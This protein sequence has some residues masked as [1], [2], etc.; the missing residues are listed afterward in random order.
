MLERHHLQIIKE[1]QRLGSVT[2]AASSLHLSQS[3][4]SHAIAKLEQR[5]GIKIWRRKGNALVYSQ[6]GQYLLSLAN[7]MVPEFEH[8]E[9]VLQEYAAGRRGIIRIGMECHPC[10]KWLMGK[11]RI[12]LKAWP[13][14]D[15]DL[16]TAF[17]FDGIAALKARE[18]DL[19]V[20]PDPSAE[21]S[22]HFTSVFNYP[23][24]IAASELNPLAQKAYVQPQ[25]LE[26]QILFTVPV[27]P[28][29]LDVY[30]QFLAPANTG[31]KQRVTIE[32]A[33]MML[34]LVAA[35]RGVAVLPKWMIAPH[36]Q[37]L[38]IKA[39]AI[40]PEGLNKSVN[41]GMR[42]EDRSLDYMQGFIAM[43]QST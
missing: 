10:E 37:E 8:A 4:I 14:V 6:S 32:T 7:K 26:S 12:F 13:Q 3:A 36:C 24:C 31:P 15:I 21:A 16:K 1:V 40:G 20:T 2:A 30:S 18:I 19:L 41:L 17:P 39:I 22:L 9:R 11:V 38:G 28:N 33:E 34:Q 25:D 29:R 27:N 43:A 35:N 42:E 5:F 23:L